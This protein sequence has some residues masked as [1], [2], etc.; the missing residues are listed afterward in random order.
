MGFEDGDVDILEMVHPRRKDC[1]S[2]YK[3]V[4]I[5]VAVNVMERVLKEV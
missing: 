2:L 1:R 4:G 3:Q 5:S